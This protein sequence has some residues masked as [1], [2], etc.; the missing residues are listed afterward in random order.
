MNGYSGHTSFLSYLP[1]RYLEKIVVD[2]QSLY[3]M[4]ELLW[5]VYC[6]H[7]SSQNLY[8]VEF[9]YKDHW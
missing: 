6:Y 3:G 2:L 1:L 7:V 5:D 9:R 8:T 4:Q